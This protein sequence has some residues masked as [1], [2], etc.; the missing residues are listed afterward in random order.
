MISLCPWIY[1]L[2]NIIGLIS[3]ESYK[4]IHNIWLWEKFCRI[5]IHP[6]PPVLSISNNWYQ[7]AVTLKRLNSLSK[8]PMDMEHLK[9]NLEEALEQISLL[10]K[11]RDNLKERYED[12]KDYI[13]K[14][15][16]KID[17]LKCRKDPREK[18]SDS[19]GVSTLKK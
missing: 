18:T 16:D 4:I 1:L 13:G 3:Y 5:L 2:F 9:R 15:K 10:T 14:L 8:I 6:L 7:T 11:E 17:H 12:A 19:D